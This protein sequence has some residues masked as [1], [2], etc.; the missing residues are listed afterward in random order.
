MSKAD[1]WK[2]AKDLYTFSSDGKKVNTDGNY[3]VD[4]VRITFKANVTMYGETQRTSTL[5]ISGM[6][7]R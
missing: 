3:S 1:N 2:E 5:T 7:S 4:L 6:Q